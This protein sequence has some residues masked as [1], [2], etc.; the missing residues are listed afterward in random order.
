MKDPQSG[1][2]WSMIIVRSFMDN[3]CFRPWLVLT[4][5]IYMVLHWTGILL[6]IKCC[7]FP[8]V[9]YVAID[10]EMRNWFFTEK[11]SLRVIHVLMIILHCWQH[12]LAK[13]SVSNFL[14]RYYGS[15]YNKWLDML[16]SNIILPDLKLLG[17]YAL[18]Y[19]HSNEVWS[20]S[21][22]FSVISSSQLA[23]L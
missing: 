3:S 13:N 12:Y 16:F 4:I 17:W 19:T 11:D 6:I 9:L 22:S 8:M 5:T 2:D 21:M 23:T 7:L 20:L 14:G 1:L 18:L 10:H 15:I